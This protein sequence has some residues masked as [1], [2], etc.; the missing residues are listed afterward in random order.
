MLCDDNGVCSHEINRRDKAG[1][2]NEFH[3]P[4]EYTWGNVYAASAN[5]MHYLITGKGSYNFFINIESLEN[6]RKSHLR[7]GEREN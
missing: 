3:I 5:K 2:S 6:Q 4:W 1:S 7:G